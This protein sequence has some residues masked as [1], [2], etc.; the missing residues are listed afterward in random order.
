[1]F[2]SGNWLLRLESNSFIIIVNKVTNEYKNLYAK[3][4]K[5]SDVIK[6]IASKLEYHKNYL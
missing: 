2:D 6:I 5:S 3:D 4:F 1:M